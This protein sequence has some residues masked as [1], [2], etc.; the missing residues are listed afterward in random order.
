MSASVSLLFDAIHL[1]RDERL[2]FAT[3]KGELLFQSIQQKSFPTRLT[4]PLWRLDDV[5]FSYKRASL[6]PTL[7]RTNRY[8]VVGPF[9]VL[10]RIKPVYSC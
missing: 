1:S 6:I 2:L 8:R 7:G 4:G 10:V 5:K 3:R 9:T